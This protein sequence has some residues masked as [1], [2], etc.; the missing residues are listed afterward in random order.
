MA[1]TKFDSNVENITA[2]PDEPS[3][4]DGYTA[5]MIK[6]L[7]DKASVD[8]KNYINNTLIPQLEAQSA[9][10]S[11]GSGNI[12]GLSAENN[13][14]SQIS[15]LKA[16]IDG[17]KDGGINS[18]SITSDKLDSETQSF[19]NNFNSRCTVYSSPGSYTFTAPRSGLYKVIISGG[20]AAGAPTGGGMSGAYGI[21]WFTLNKNEQVSLTVGAGGSSRGQG[22]DNSV[23]GTMTAEGGK[24][25]EGV[26][27]TFS[28]C[29]N[30][31]ISI[32]GGL[33]VYEDISIDIARKY[34]ADS[35]LGRGSKS[36]THT[37]GIGAGGYGVGTV[38]T[39]GGNGIIII[40]YMHIQ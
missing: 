8:L 4:E 10:A 40:E 1:F 20:G 18:A 25:G 11:V 23:F 12:S 22:G 6:S 2:L 9:S 37:A 32:D 15:A 7:F 14:F 24:A 36:Q 29:T 33:Y 19:I 35:P 16:L 17:I 13:V 28:S 21:K 27:D 39:A 31:D 5:A 34:G 26:Y 3:Q 30:A 38:H